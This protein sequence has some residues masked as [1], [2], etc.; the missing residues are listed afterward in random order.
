M[1]VVVRCW[2][3]YISLIFFFFP[4]S[5]RQTGYELVKPRV[6]WSFL[7][8]FLLSQLVCLSLYPEFGLLNEKISRL[9]LKSSLNQSYCYSC[10]DIIIFESAFYF[11]LHL[12]LRLISAETHFPLNQDQYAFP[13]LFFV[14]FPESRQCGQ[15]K[16]SRNIIPILCNSLLT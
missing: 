10:N 4:F 5:S 2:Y 7:V 12:A 15:L 8:L 11:A 14:F 13:F 1:T 6:V 16:K 3:S 9:T